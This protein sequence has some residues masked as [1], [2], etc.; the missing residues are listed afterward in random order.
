MFKLVKIDYL[1]MTKLLS[2]RKYVNID[3]FFKQNK[4]TVELE[5]H[6]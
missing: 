1:G 6:K 4:D 5:M 3:Q 2:D